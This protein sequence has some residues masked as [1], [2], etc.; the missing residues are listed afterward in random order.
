M[1]GTHLSTLQLISVAIIPTLFAIVVHEVAHGWVA[2]RLGDPTAKMLGRLTLNPIKHIDPIGTVLVPLILLVTVGFAF[3]WAKP[4]PV[5]WSNLRHPRRDTAWVALAGPAANFLM[6][7]GWGI[8]SKVATLLPAAVDTYALPLAYMGMF[9]M[10]INIILMVFNLIPVPP[11]DGGRIAVSLLP[12]KMGY[13]L[14]RVEPFGIPILLVL[15]LTGVLWHLLN[16]FIG[17]ILRLIQTLV[18]I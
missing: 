18:G 4:V 6:A 5:T 17:G 11:T 3:G 2:Y 9:G 15:L 12:P 16:P 14:S 10:L 13:T 1:F 8:I 7:I